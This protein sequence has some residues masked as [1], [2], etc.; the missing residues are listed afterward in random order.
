MAVTAVVYPY[1]CFITGKH[2]PLR[3]SDSAE[4]GVDYSMCRTLIKPT[5]FLPILIYVLIFLS[6]KPFS[7]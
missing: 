2:L 6:F 4:R 1:N 7:F 5:F 3:R